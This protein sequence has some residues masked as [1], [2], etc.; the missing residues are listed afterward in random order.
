MIEN[1]SA[2]DSFFLQFSPPGSGSRRELNADPDADRRV[3]FSMFCCYVLAAMRMPE[4]GVYRP[5]YI[6]RV[7]SIASVL[8]PVLLGGAGGGDL[9]PNSPHVPTT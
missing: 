1:V 9:A 6:L 2:I 5:T 7:S 8:P 3:T 4:S